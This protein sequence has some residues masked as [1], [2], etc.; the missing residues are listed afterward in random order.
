[1]LFC[2]KVQSFAWCVFDGK[3][4]PNK[5]LPEKNRIEKMPSFLEYFSWLFFFAGFLSGPVGEF[6]DYISFSNRTMFKNEV[7]HI[8]L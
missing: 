3:R 4:P 5:F 6:Q 7:C 8:N 1:M 2:I